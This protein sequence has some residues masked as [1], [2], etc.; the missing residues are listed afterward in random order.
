MWQ[1]Y[2]RRSGEFRLLLFLLLV[3]FG[4][5]I[6]PLS[7]Q[8]QTAS[9]NRHQEVLH[10]LQLTPAEEKQFWPVYEAYSKALLQ[11]FEQTADVAYQLFQKRAG[12]SDEMA[13]EYTRA[14]L[15]GELRQAQIHLEFQPRFRGVLGALRTARLF[16]FERRLQS[17][18]NAEIA[19]EFPLI[20]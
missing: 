12:V 20:R 2:F 19:R 15:N 9:E 18:M 13:D 14:L 17:Y 11:T 3:G 10:E 16:Q 4:L 1:K 6:T 8:A 7:G 5:S